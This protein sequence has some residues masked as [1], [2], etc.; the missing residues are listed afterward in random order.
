MTTITTTGT[1]TAIDIPELKATIGSKG[2][3]FTGTLPAT[4]EVG[5]LVDG[6]FAAMTGGAVTSTPASFVVE[7]IPPEGL[8]LNVS[9]GSPDFSITS[10]GSKG[11]Y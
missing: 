10:T 8:A 9:G 6:V 4:L 2:L 11:K 7:T 5:I 1:K 3:M